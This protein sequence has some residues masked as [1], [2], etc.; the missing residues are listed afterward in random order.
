L[1]SDEAANLIDA[2]QLGQSGRYPLYEDLGR[3]QY[4]YMVLQGFSSVLVGTTVFVQRVLTVLYGVLTMAALYWAGVQCAYDLAPIARRFVGVLAAVVLSVTLGH[5]VMSRAIERGVLQ[6]LITPLWLGFLARG[7]R[8]ARWR[9]FVVAGILLAVLLNTYTAALFV[10]LAVF[11]LGVML[12]LWRGRHWRS[13]LPRLIVMGLVCGLCSSYLLYTL[14]VTPKAIFGRAADV[15]SS[16]FVWT[17]LP[18]LLV[19]LLVQRGDFNPQYNINGAVVV[20][21]AWVWWLAGG[22]LV[23]VLRMRQPLSV[24]LGTLLVLAVLPVVLSNEIPHGLR[25]AGAFPIFPLLIGLFFGTLLHYALR[26]VPVVWVLRGGSVIVLGLLFTQA[27]LTHETYQAFW[28]EPE[29]YRTWRMFNQDL[30]HAEWFYRVDRRALGDWLRAQTTPI[31]LPLAEVQRFTTY[32]WLLP[33]F[34]Q[35]ESVTADFQLPPMTRLF[36]PYWLEQDG[37]LMDAAQYVL[38]DG[39]TLYFLPPFDAATITAL[40]TTIETG[41]RVA[42]GDGALAFLGMVQPLPPNL[43]VRYAPTVPVLP[44]QFEDEIALATI[45]GSATLATDAR[46]VEYTIGWQALRPLG[47]HYASGVQLLTQEYQRVGSSRD[48]KILLSLHPT[49]RWRVGEVVPVRYALTIP[50]SLPPGAYRLTAFIYP[51]FRAPLIPQGVSGT[52]PTLAWLKVPQTERVQPSATA[53]PLDITFADTFRLTHIEATR[54][55][56]EQ[57]QVALYWTTLQD[58]PP[59]DATIFVH[60]LDEDGALS[61]QADS[62]PWGGQYPTFIWETGEIIRTDHVLNVAD[63]AGVQFRL[64][65][66]L[67]TPT[68]QNLPAHSGTAPKSDGIV[69]LGAI[70]PVP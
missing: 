49:T 10:P 68:L 27:Q 34:P 38:L 7:L 36:S 8:T 32:A 48:E 20:A 16:S 58:R 47:H 51:E 33:R 35:V 41:E 15:S 31:L 17:Q 19:D 25:I 24:V 9:D 62:R 4:L 5:I 69:E 43:T 11:P 23:L 3:P 13:W 28:R 6:V 57:I 26:Y 44:V 22:V 59:Q 37:L 39:D 14:L 55:N 1:S 21:T 12:L 56:A 40:Q 63:G 52:L 45:Y 46:S 70:V 54:L 42:A 29:Q 67:L 18:A 66:Y 50:E 61:G 65:M 64:G 60:V 53:I 30:T 2:V